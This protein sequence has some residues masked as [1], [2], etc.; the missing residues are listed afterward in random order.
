MAAA[1]T[2][3]VW[4]VA[5]F[6]YPLLVGA[7]ADFKCTTRMKIAVDSPAKTAALAFFTVLV[8]GAGIV[9]YSPELNGDQ[10]DD[11]L[12]SPKTAIEYLKEH[13]PDKQ[14][15]ILTN[16]DMGGYVEW[17]GYKVTMDPRPELWN[18]A[19]TGFD[20]DYYYEFV[21]L[22]KE[23]VSPADYMEDKDDRIDYAIVDSD[24]KLYKYLS[25]SQDYVNIL[26]GN[27]YSLFGHAR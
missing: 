24:T 1:H 26:S 27:G 5:V 11:A 13:E 19:I 17:N 25:A 9:A 20:K 10:P 15:R 8:L 12:K 21:Q 3:N 4:L 2:R 16:F 22:S 14:L 23:E 18:S 6:A 7:F